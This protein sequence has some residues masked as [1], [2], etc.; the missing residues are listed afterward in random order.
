MSDSHEPALNGD[1]W[2]FVGL[3]KP[4]AI[5]THKE[6]RGSCNIHWLPSK[7][8]VFQKHPLKVILLVHELVE[9]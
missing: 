7:I 3:H 4:Q 1:P 8:V 2:D 5:D 6:S 9:K